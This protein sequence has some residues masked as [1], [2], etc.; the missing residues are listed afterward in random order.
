M[1][2]FFFGAFD[3]TAV[4]RVPLRTAL[5]DEWAA[6]PCAAAVI[7]AENAHDPRTWAALTTGHTAAIFGLTYQGATRTYNRRQKLTN[8]HYQLALLG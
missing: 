4:Q 1:L 2:P 5:G 8:G 3:G 7:D 6:A